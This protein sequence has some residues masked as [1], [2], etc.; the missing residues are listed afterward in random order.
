MPAVYKV[1]TSIYNP[2]K[3]L[4]YNFVRN[5]YITLQFLGIGFLVLV[6]IA[7]IALIAGIKIL[8]DDA[9][10]IQEDKDNG[11]A[12]LKIG[13]IGLSSIFAIG[14]TKQIL[15]WMVLRRNSFV[16]LILNILFDVTVASLF[17]TMFFSENTGA[18]F[19]S[20][21]V[22]FCFLDIFML[23]FLFL[24]NKAYKF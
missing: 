9:Q 10:T 22:S 18:A 11:T 4:L 6:F 1:Q 7:D 13:I 20:V 12:L 19:F 8:N 14:L 23:S 21:M 17:L 2:R 16:S 15:S 5:F 24:S 3:S